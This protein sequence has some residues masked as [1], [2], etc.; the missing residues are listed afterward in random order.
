MLRTI[1]LRFY[2][3]ENRRF[4]QQGTLCF[5][6]SGCFSVSTLS[7]QRLVRLFARFVLFMGGS[8]A[9]PSLL[10]CPSQIAENH[11]DLENIFRCVHARF[12]ASVPPLWVRAQKRICFYVVF[13]FIEF[14]LSIRAIMVKHSDNVAPSYS[15]IVNTLIN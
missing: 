4:I 6:V 8:S 10:I 11:L 7:K 9:R 2:V 1:L 15:S 3:G 5:P 14:E 13:L 12:C